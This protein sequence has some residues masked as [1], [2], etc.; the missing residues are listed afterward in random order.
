MAQ[1]KVKGQNFIHDTGL[2][3]WTYSAPIVER[4]RRNDQLSQSWVEDRA[5]SHEHLEPS[6]QGSAKSF[7]KVVP[8]KSDLP[9]RTLKTKYSRLFFNTE[10]TKDVSCPNTP[11]W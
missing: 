7:I 4:C 11:G 3:V 5:A 1:D 8:G 10:K 6:A 2:C 9:G